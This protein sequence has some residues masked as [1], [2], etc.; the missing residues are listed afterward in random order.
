MERMPNTL[1]GLLQARL[2]RLARAER[3]AL[4]QAAIVGFV[5]WDEAVAAIDP[6]SAALLAS[7]QR[8]ELIVQ[9]AEST[10][11]GAQEF[12]FHHHTLHQVARDGVLKADRARY[13]QRVGEWLERRTAQR[14][15]EFHGRIA[16]HFERANE[17]ARAL[18]HYVLGAEAAVARYSRET[19]LRYA[20]RALALAPNDNVDARWRLHAAREVMLA[21]ADERDVHNADLAAMARLADD[22][23][24]DSRRA[25]AAWREAVASCSAGDYPDALATAQAAERLANAANDDATAAAATGTQATALRRLNDFQQARQVAERGLD[26]ARACNS[27]VAEKELLYSL[28]ALAA[29]SGRLETSSRLG[30]NY[31]SLARSSG[32]QSAEALALNLIGDSAYRLGDL[33]RARRYLEDSL[34]LAECIGYPYCECIASLNLALV[35]N[36]Q[37]RFDD[38]AGAGRKAV[39]IAVQ[40]GS[41][42]LEAVALLQLG[43]AQ[44][45]CGDL[46]AARATLDAAGDRYETN[47]SAHLRVETDSA[48]ALVALKAGDREE[49][50][51]RV[52]RVMRYFDSNGTLDGTEDPV[53]IRWS[54]FEVLRALDDPRTEAWL[55]DSWELINKRSQQIE[56]GEKRAAYT[57]S[58]VHHAA[59]TR[60]WEAGKTR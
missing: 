22:L 3:R 55:A 12:A 48:L 27:L 36:G 32:D 44:A 8:R 43:L 2:D 21:T 15:G 24:D 20:Q 25:I 40:S 50:A 23:N 46:A 49:A 56:A 60:A 28:A 7:L 39:S 51:A 30:G 26:Q 9:R 52:Q 54:C 57:K 17:Q 34:A 14:P 13:H 47:G 19:V 53:R 29:E 38:A 6:A 4:R 41:A 1:T 33:P 37:G 10:L 42:D 45:G 31:L 16:L 5:F 58:T 35:A 18:H 11:Q 59:L